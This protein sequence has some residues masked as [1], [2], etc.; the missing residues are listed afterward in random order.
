M[1]ANTDNKRI[2][3]LGDF[4]AHISGYLHDGPSDW[5]GRNLIALQ[6]TFGLNIWNQ[7]DQWT[8]TRKIKRGEEGA[9]NM[10][11]TIIDWTISCKNTEI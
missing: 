10:S 8:C 4:N 5:G 7:N 9:G 2:I 11:Y 6:E 3:I 1:Q